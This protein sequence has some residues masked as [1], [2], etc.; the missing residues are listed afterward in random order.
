MMILE[1]FAVRVE[2]FVL[3]ALSLN[4]GRALPSPRALPSLCANS[5]GPVS[6][7]SVVDVVRRCMSALQSNDDPRPDAGKRT[8]WDLA[9]DM[10]R[11]EHGGDVDRFIRWCAHPSHTGCM[12]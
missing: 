11:A 12:E 2:M 6:Q 3:S 10:I 8:N 7:L 1:T 9:S 5:F 4:A